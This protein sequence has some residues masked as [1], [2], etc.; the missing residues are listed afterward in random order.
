MANGIDSTNL[1]LFGQQGLRLSDPGVLKTSRT[2]MAS[3]TA[4]WEIKKSN[5]RNLRGIGT[6]HP[7]FSILSMESSEVQLKGAYAV[8]TANYTGVEAQY[9]DLSPTYELVV[10]LS[11]EPIETHTKFQTDIGG[12]PMAPLNG[13]MF[14]NQATKIWVF[15]GST[16]TAADNNGYLFRGFMV[17][18]PDTGLLNSYAKIE[19]YLE[20]SQLTWRRTTARRTSATS[21]AAV[22]KIGTP[23]GPA[24][25]LPAGRNWLYMGLTQTQRGNVYS[26]V[27]EWRASGRRGWNTTIYS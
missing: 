25:S 16:D 21:I 12:T 18:D 13:A 27:E 7:I 4:V 1:E 6:P 10:G 14:E 9:D 19:H 8:Q 3:C 17:T 22:G 26:V 2:G 5:Y 20:A 23:K 24:P 11:E 15:D